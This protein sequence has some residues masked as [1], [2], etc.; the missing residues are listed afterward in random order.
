MSILSDSPK[1]KVLITGASAGIGAVY[2]DRFAGRGHDLVL[3]ARD[4]SRLEALARKLRGQTGVRIEVLPADLSVKADVL[5][6]EAK[7]KDDA[8][9]GV[10]V[11]N[12]GIAVP[13]AV[14]GGDPDALE[15]LIQINVTAAT[16]IAAAAA[17]AFAAKKRGAIVNVASVLGLLPERTHPVYGG[18][19]AFLINFSQALNI[20]LAPFGVQ[21]QAVLPGATRTEIWE[22]SGKDVATIDPAMLMEVDDLVDAA[23]AGFDARELVTIP[24]LPDVAD[25]NAFEAARLKLA[26]NLSRNRSAG[27]YRNVVRVQACL[28]RSDPAAPDRLR[29]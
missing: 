12:A 9:I 22:R 5:R 21:V 23:L 13:G 24:S 29:G 16:R 14:T 27:R 17:A 2:A 11:N 20:E 8:T 26:P 18:S 25:W 6:V 15:R 10:L 4:V 19:K 1:D 7:L 28:S 3:V